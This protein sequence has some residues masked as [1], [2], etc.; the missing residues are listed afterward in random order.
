MFPFG[1]CSQLAEVTALGAGLE[2]LQALTSLH[3]NFFGCSQLAEVSAL[4]EGVGKLQAL[5][6]LAL[7]FAGCSSGRSVKARAPRAW[8]RHVRWY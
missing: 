6:S 7:Y 1:G 4:G 2:K 5:T 8:W 3:L